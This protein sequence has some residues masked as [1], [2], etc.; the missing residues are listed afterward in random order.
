MMGLCARACTISSTFRS[1]A[2]RT[3]CS[4]ASSK[5]STRRYDLFVQKVRQSQQPDEQQD[6]S[7]TTATARCC[8]RA[9]DVDEETKAGHKGGRVLQAHHPPVRRA[10]EHG[11]PVRGIADQQERAGESGHRLYRGAHGQGLRYRPLRNS[12]TRYSAIPERVNALKINIRALSRPR[13]TLSGAGGDQTRSRTGACGGAAR[14]PKRTWTALEA[15]Q[16]EPLTAS[17]IAVR[18]GATWVDKAYYK[19]FYCELV[20]L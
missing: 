7:R 20:G 4:K 9:R 5:S 6:S 2:A 14:I 16:P 1:Q 8:L 19:H 17:E 15:V 18:L 10:D 13:N 3:R 11:R 12:A